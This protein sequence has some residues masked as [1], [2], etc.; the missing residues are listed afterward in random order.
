MNST[1]DPQFAGIEDALRAALAF[2]PLTA[3]HRCADRII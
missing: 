2:D 1:V 3:L